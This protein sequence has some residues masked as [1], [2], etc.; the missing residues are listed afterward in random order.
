MKL[1]DMGSSATFYAVD[2]ENDRTWEVD[3]R[4]YVTGV[5][6]RRLTS[7][8]EMILQFAHFIAEELERRGRGQ[9]EIRAQVLA[10]LNGRA[11][12]LLVDPEVDLASIPRSLAPAGWIV[13]LYE[14]I[15]P[16]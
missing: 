10:S 12:Q 15:R 14:Q 13:P 16:R 4:D 8:P 9:V 1:Q 2:R 7:S 3:L 5:Q 11:P 6:Y